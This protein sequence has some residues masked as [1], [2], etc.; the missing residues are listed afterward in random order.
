VVDVH[1]DIGVVRVHGIHEV[2]ST[3][4]G[5]RADEIVVGGTGA[6]E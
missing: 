5:Q 1:V 6:L 3:V 2:P 4:A